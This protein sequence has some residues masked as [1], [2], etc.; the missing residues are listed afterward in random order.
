MSTVITNLGPRRS[1]PTIIGDILFQ[2]GQRRQIENPK[3]I[4]E[5]KRFPFLRFKDLS[6]PDKP[7]SVSTAAPPARPST[8]PA[9]A[10]LTINA[11]RRLAGKIHVPGAFTM[12][13]ARLIKI[14][15]EQYHG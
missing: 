9:F 2:H 11:L 8:E 3:A 12:K 4:E 15:E 13:K 6:Q 7:V 14:L 10:T 5:L 1:L